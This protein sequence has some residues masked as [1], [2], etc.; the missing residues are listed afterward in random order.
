MRIVIATGGTGGHI[1]PA[2]S[3]LEEIKRKKYSYL[4]VADKRFNNFKNAMSDDLNVKIVQ[5]SG[6]SGSV[7]NRL[8]SLFRLFYGTIQTL[9]IFKKFKPNIVV[10]FGGYPAI[11]SMLSAKILNIPLVIQ[12][13]NSVVGQAS[14][15]FLGSAAAV[16][17]SFEHTQGIAKTQN[18]YLTGTPV[19][20]SILEVRKQAYPKLSNS[21]KI[22]I[23]VIGGSQG[24]KIL[25]QVLPLAFTKLPDAIRKR[26]KIT[27]QVRSE[28]IEAVKK[29]YKKHDIDAKI[30]SFFVDMDIKLAE[31]HLVICRAGATTIAELIAVGRPSVLVP[32][33]A[34]K[35]NHQ[36]LNAEWLV[37]NNAGWMITES[38]FSIEKC[39]KQL[40][41]IL[42]DDKTIELFAQ[43]AR[44]LFLDSSNILLGLIEKYCTSA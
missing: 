23:L 8:M 20:S 7:I 36:V 9:L 16:A 5:S 35:E 27:Q 13:P 29:I 44:G 37:T 10:S 32:I 21:S 22:N 25:G 3:L 17:C 33:A 42:K 38:D 34:S 28:D 6:F 19:R 2:L 15:I 12:E 43:Q 31:A 30:E 26:L 11:P 14:K 40:E 18:V 39:A 4:I 41:R 1:F 24:A